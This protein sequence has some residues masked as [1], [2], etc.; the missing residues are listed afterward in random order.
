MGLCQ[1]LFNPVVLSR[2]GAGDLRI[3]ISK[4][5]RDGQQLRVFAS[6]IEDP[7]FIPSTHI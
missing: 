4:G 7:D 6:L 2:T 5:R 3:Q 1:V